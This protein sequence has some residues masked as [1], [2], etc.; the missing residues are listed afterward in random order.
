MNARADNDDMTVV[1]ILI[2]VIA[3]LLASIPF[4]VDS[5][6]TEAPGRFRPN[7]R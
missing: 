2:V 5:R 6:R 7:W 1:L 4:G 3:V